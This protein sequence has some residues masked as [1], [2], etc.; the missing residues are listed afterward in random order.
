MVRISFIESDGRRLDIDAEAGTTVMQAALDH[1]VRGLVAE[2]GGS[3]VCGTC[4]CYIDDAW[5]AATGTPS[6]DELA[7]I[8]Y[9]EH[10]RPNSR[11][12]C[13][14][15]VSAATEGMVVRLPPA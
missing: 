8:S 4:Q 12:S 11:L 1:G 14:V 7:L 10:P 3:Q 15:R 6:E 13:Q 9:S 5:L 2:C